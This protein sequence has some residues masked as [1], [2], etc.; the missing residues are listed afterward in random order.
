MKDFLVYTALRVL[1]FVACYAVLGGLW[2]AV[3]GRDGDAYLVGPFVLAAIVSSFL[4]LKFLKG[5]RERFARRIESRAARA[6]QRFERFKARED[7]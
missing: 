1:L 5:P 2:L 6:S 7:A 4:S 3:L